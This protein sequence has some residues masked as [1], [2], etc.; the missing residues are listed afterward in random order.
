M[1]RLS[2]VVW[3]LLCLACLICLVG[4]G[5][6]PAAPS[7]DPKPSAS[8]SSS[9][10]AQEIPV[11]FFHDTACGSCDGTAEFLEAVGDTI[12]VYRETAPYDLRMYNVFQSDGRAGLEEALAAYG[13]SPVAPQT[14]PCMLLGGQLFEGW[15]AIRGG[16]EQDYPPVAEG[17]SSLFGEIRTDASEATAVYFYRADCPECQETEPFFDGLS[18]TVAV[19]GEERALNLI[20]LNSRE[21]SNGERI[22]ALFDA[23]GVP[24]EDQIVPIVFLTDSYLAGKD[25]IEEELLPRLREGGGL[26]FAF[27]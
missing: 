24:A 2:A 22:R 7:G 16:L 9:G 26:G 17:K 15:E 20:R 8:L 1:K 3:K 4:S 14:F 12:S 10:G 19:Q 21:G 18:Q 27:P 6:T 13:L 23:Y 11:Y 25:A 5:C